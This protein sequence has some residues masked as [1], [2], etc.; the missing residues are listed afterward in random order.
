VSTE[1]H[2]EEVGTPTGF[3][4]V[5]TDGKTFGL[6]NIVTGEFHKETFSSHEAARMTAHAVTR[7]AV[8]GNKAN[9]EKYLLPPH[10]E[11]YLL[12]LGQI[13]HGCGVAV[14]P[15]EGCCVE[16]GMP[17]SAEIDVNGVQFL[18]PILLPP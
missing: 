16:C 11:K 15:E 3:F 14:P 7:L 18:R 10:R 17:P 12:L 2:I 1:C 9:R 6:R 4:Q 5:C 13:C 8:R